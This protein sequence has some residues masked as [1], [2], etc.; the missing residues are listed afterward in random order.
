MEYSF[1][2]FDLNDKSEIELDH[3]DEQGEPLRN[4]KGRN[5]A[6]FASD[7]DSRKRYH[8]FRAVGRHAMLYLYTEEALYEVPE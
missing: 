7:E 4:F 2:S 3:I 5:Y 1:I 6:F 8:P